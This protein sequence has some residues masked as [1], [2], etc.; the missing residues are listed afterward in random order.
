MVKKI[1]KIGL[2]KIKGRLKIYKNTKT[3]KIPNL[4]KNLDIDCVNY[5]AIKFSFWEKNKNKIRLFRTK[6]KN[7]KFGWF[8]QD[9]VVGLGKNDYLMVKLSGF[10][11]FGFLLGRLNVK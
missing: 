8:K 10:L 1:T 11:L 3:M 9:L 7:K 2:G 5:D 4:M 6:V